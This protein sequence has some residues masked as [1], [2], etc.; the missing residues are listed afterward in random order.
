M[1]ANRNPT[2]DHLGGFHISFDPREPHRFRTSRVP[3][4]EG[5][6]APNSYLPFLPDPLKLAGMVLTLAAPLMKSTFVKEKTMADCSLLAQ[7]VEIVNMMGRIEDLPTLIQHAAGG[8]KRLVDSES[9]VFYLLSE[10]DPTKFVRNGIAKVSQE[11][12]C[13]LLMDVVKTKEGIQV[14]LGHGE[15]HQKLNLQYANHLGVGEIRN[16]LLCPISCE[17]KMY[18][19]IEVVNKADGE[20]T[21]LDS[22]LVESLGNYAAVSIQHNNTIKLLNNTS[23]KASAM[24]DVCKDL[25]AVTL[26]PEALHSSVMEH[27][28]QIVNADRASLFICDWQRKCLVA[29]FGNQIVTMPINKGIAGTVATTGENLNIL[30]AYSDNRFN[31]SIDKKS[32]YRTKTLLAVPVKCDGQVVAVAQLINKKAPAGGTPL[33]F[34]AEDEDLLESFSNFAGISLRISAQ[35]KDLSKERHKFKTM[36]DAVVGVADT[37]I[38][39]GVNTLCRTIMHQAKQLILADRCSLFM[40][41]KENSQLYSCVTDQQ[42]G[43]IRFGMHQGIAGQ[44]VRL[45]VTLNIPDAYKDQHFNTENDRQRGYHTKTILAAPIKFEGDAI[46]VMQLINKAGDIPFDEEDEETLNFFATLAGITIR[47]SQLYEFA[48]KGSEEIASVL[49]KLNNPGQKSTKEEGPLASEREKDLME[50]VLAVEKTLSRRE[51]DSACLPTFDIHVYRSKPDGLESAI[52]IVHEMFELRGLIDLFCIDREVLYRFLIR[53]ALGYRNVPYHS[54]YH[55]IDVTQTLFQY[56]YVLPQGTFTKLEEFVLL[57][58]GICHDVDHMGLNNSFHYKAETPLGILSSATG[59]S[60]PLEI[61]HCNYSIEILQKGEYNIF[62]NFPNQADEVQAYKLMVKCILGTDMA[63]HGKL[64]KEMQELQPHDIATGQKETCLTVLLK[65]ADISNVT[66]PF[67][68]SRMWAYYVLDEFYMQGDQEARTMGEI[69]N[70]MFDRNNKKEVAEGQLGFMGF[71][72][73]FY[74]QVARVFPELQFLI[75]QLEENERSWRGV[76]ERQDKERLEMSLMQSQIRDAPPRRSTSA[77]VKLAN[78]A[79]KQ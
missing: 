38:R 71:V 69:S 62:A 9:C 23:K 44:T 19:V 76:Q 43:E 2:V 5:A 35:Y 75:H 17:N 57:I 33:P 26:D 34:D 41:D 27:A 51:L 36:L 10:S 18:G 4:D 65:A 67:E 52:R 78:S 70:E 25:A 73:P 49:L 8:A 50:R 16:I 77:S 53:V 42:G 31:Q 47:N 22:M 60:S 24:L 39:E 12:T 28:R 13:G 11:H 64:F 59:G 61:H 55:A 20:F 29:T 54:V 74:T 58:C 72:K 45:G 48:T 30:D 14:E 56:L 46:A 7:I 21:R 32:G 68:I 37:D 40:L 63:H 6:P 66:K 3:N 1:L 15:V 79:K